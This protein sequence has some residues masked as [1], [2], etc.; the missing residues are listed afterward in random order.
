MTDDARPGLEWENRCP[1]CRSPNLDVEGLELQGPHLYCTD[2]GEVF[3]RSEAL[4]FRL[5]LPPGLPPAEKN[6]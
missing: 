3:H 1:F 4:R 2:C 6:T 5:V